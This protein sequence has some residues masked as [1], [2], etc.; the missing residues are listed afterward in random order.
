M[1]DK[2][3]NLASLQGRLNNIVTEE[4]RSLARLQRAIAN[5]VIGQM[6]PPGVVKGGTA[7]KARLGELASRFTPDFDAAR[8]AR[9]GLEEYLEQ[10][11]DKLAEGWGGFTGTIQTVDGVQPEDVPEEYVMKPYDIRLAYEGRH[12]LKVRFELGR[13][14]VDSTEHFQMRLAQ[15][16][17][18]LF[19]QLGLPTPEPLPV[20]LAEHQVAQKLHACTSVSPKTG[21]NERAHDLVD[22]QL[23]EEEEEVELAAVNAIAT[24]L[25]AGR[26]AQIWPPGV[27]AY[28][29]WDMLYAKAAEG[30]NVMADVDEAVQWA[31]DFIGRVVAAGQAPRGGGGD[32]AAAI[33]TG[34]GTGD[35]GGAAAADGGGDTTPAADGGEGA[36]AR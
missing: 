33:A 10:L 9:L 27:R 11:E 32:G 6:L 17:I 13:D 7:M 36:A 14:E 8:A 35:R 21:R 26:G 23:L 2:P 31:N 20:M 22:L 28:D 12:W 19:Q 30:L 16:I 5:T 29:G 24:R 34:A 3:R 25:F 4:G 1:R 18:E 15:D